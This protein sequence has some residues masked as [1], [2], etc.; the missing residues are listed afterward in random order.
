MTADKTTTTYNVKVPVDASDEKL[1]E[2]A[3]KLQ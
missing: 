3:G 2:I 1:S